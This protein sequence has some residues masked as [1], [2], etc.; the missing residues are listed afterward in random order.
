METT[1]A[2]NTF[3]DPL[4][5]VVRLVDEIW[6]DNGL[7]GILVSSDMLD[8]HAIGERIIDQ[9]EQLPKFNPFRPAMHVNAAASV[10]GILREKSAGRYGVV[11][12]PCEM[13]ALIQLEKLD[14]FPR[15]HLVTICVDCLGT[16][17]ANDLEWRTERRGSADGLASDTLKFARQGGISVDRYRAACQ[18]CRSSGAE[19]ADVN[20]WVIGLP[21]RQ[22]IMVNTPTQELAG[23]FHFAKS[24]QVEADNELMKMRRRVLERVATRNQHS[25]E[26]FIQELIDSLP[27]TIEAIAEHLEQC[28]ECRECLEA[29]PIC[30]ARRIERGPDGRYNRREIA[31]WLAACA[32]CGMCEQ[33]CVKNIP[34][35]AVFGVIH[36]RMHIIH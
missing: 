29:C 19:D 22:V 5:S 16:F 8:N 12:R 14:P 35:S 28:G 36:D 10:P 15:E 27:P 30:S 11:L 20:I 13:R 6:R 18:I 23:K 25:R 31:Q 4:G 24:T 7:D 2:I 17:P 9:P 32:G 21:A 3:G 1:W 26:R 34:L 33:A